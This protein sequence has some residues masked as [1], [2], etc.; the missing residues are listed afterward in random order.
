MI[1]F[2]LGGAFVCLG[3]MT[4]KLTKKERFVRIRS[5]PHLY[6]VPAAEENSVL[7]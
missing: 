7:L 6:R 3:E 1:E 4:H 5:C 2:V